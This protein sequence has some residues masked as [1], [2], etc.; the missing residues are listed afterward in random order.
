MVIKCP[1]CNHYVSDTAN[2][3]PTCGYKLN[4]D[5]SKGT[6][7][8]FD[9]LT[10]F[11]VSIDNSE[12]WYSFELENGVYIN[13]NY[14]DS[15]VQL[16]IEEFIKETSDEHFLK[17]RDAYQKFKLSEYYSDFTI[18]DDECSESHILLNCTSRVNSPTPYIA[19]M[20]I[21]VFGVTSPNQIEILDT[22]G[23]G[24]CEGV[25]SDFTNDEEQI[26]ENSINDN[27]SSVIS[28]SNH[29]TSPDI[30]ELTNPIIVEEPQETISQTEIPHDE[31]I[32]EDFSSMQMS[33]AAQPSVDVSTE[34]SS[35][36]SKDTTR[37]QY[38]RNKTLK[39]KSDS[40]LSNP[41]FLVLAVVLICLF[42]FLLL[43]YSGER[44]NSKENDSVNNIKN[45][46]DQQLIED[47]LM[48]VVKQKSDSIAYLKDSLNNIGQNKK[49]PN[50]R[51]TGTDLSSRKESSSFRYETVQNGT[52]NMGYAIFKGT[53]VS[54][55]PHGVDGRLTFKRPHQIDS[56][57]PKGR[58]AEPGDYVIGE[59]YEGHLVQGIWYDAYNQ[60]KG[61][62]IIGR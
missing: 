60:V 44:S 55:R 33:Q 62:I 15:E 34:Q 29:D 27:Q 31:N 4:S 13:C 26:L 36:T 14:M 54:G 46:Q 39:K 28:E 42:T 61:S 12:K 8:S 53:L 5:A 48:K 6:F 35:S 17:A 24:L 49:S 18:E 23:D 58:I 57:D 56:R 38:A 22:G 47:S 16:F 40:F 19:K 2:T 1:N 3:C 45:A 51:T 41:W 7:S 25:N 30:M 43:F 52:K 21:T 50:N 9:E 20:L 10:S 11:L 59:F 32:Q 37:E